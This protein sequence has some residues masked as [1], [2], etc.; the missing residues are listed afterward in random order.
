MVGS[1]RG[2][3]HKQEDPNHGHAISKILEVDSFELLKG[4]EGDP[5]GNTLEDYLDGSVRWRCAVRG[6]VQTC[7]GVS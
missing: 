4:R 1:R 3:E 6:G 2:G 5:S 7:S